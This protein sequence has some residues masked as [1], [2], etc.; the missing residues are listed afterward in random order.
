MTM[1]PRQDR[2]NFPR[3]HDEMPGVAQQRL[4]LE[5]SNPI[6]GQLACFRLYNAPITGANTHRKPLGAL[7]DC[8]ATYRL[9]SR[10]PRDQRGPSWYFDSSAERSS[11]SGEARTAAFGDV[12]GRVIRESYRRQNGAILADFFESWEVL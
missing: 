8:T 9:P 5:E 11:L 10:I 7:G 4:L 2:N 3:V 6:I 12:P 1:Y